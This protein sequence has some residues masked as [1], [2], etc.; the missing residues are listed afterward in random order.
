[1]SRFDI[2]SESDIIEGAFKE[3]F[4]VVDIADGDFNHGGRALCRLALR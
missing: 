3:G 2:F 4:V 1:M